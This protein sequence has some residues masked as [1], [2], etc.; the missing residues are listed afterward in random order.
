MVYQFII[1]PTITVQDFHPSNPQPTF[2]EP[3]EL[4]LHEVV[5]VDGRKLSLAWLKTD[6]FPGEPILGNS[7]G[8]TPWKT[9]K[10]STSCMDVFHK[11]FFIG[12]MQ[13][14]FWV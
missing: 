8:E 13:D 5:L 9:M 12:N 4:M 3:A 10:C 11:D 2:R 7:Q 14:G 6:E 1:I